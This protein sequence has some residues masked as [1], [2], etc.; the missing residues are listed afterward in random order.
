[1]LALTTDATNNQSAKV[2][3]WNDLWAD[4]IPRCCQTMCTFLQIRYLRLYLQNYFLIKY[5]DA[6]TSPDLLLPVSS[7]RLGTKLDTQH[8]KGNPQVIESASL[9]RG[10]FAEI[11]CVSS[12]RLALEL[13]AQPVPWLQMSFITVEIWNSFWGMFSWLSL[14][15]F[16]LA[17][18]Q[19]S[20]WIFS[21]P[22]GL[23]KPFF[24]LSLKRQQQYCMSF[25]F[26]QSGSHFPPTALTHSVNHQGKYH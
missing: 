13:Q 16:I 8:Q 20:S 17:N 11:M 7:Q 1:M 12:P 25:E 22:V 24:P 21:F 26:M 23:A 10:E 18:F 6:A 3:C 9:P 14:I 2:C 15:S 19:F 4:M 5:G